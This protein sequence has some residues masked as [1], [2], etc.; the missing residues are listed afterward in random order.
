MTNLYNPLRKPATPDASELAFYLSGIT[1]DAQ[2][3]LLS[4]SV[5]LATGVSDIQ[6]LGVRFHYDE[7]QVSY[8]A[9]TAY[10]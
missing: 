1:Y 4:L 2:S 8:T 9:D 10:S 7:S 3:N 5:G 6:S